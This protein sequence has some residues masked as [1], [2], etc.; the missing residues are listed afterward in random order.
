[1]AVLAARALAEA[2]AVVERAVILR[3]LDSWELNLA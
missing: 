2:A 3:L 1:M